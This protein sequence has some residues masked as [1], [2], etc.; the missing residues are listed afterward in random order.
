MKLVVITAITEYS[1]DIKKILKTSNVKAFSFKEVTGY[2]DISEENIDSN[3][4]GSDMNET[5][6]VL[7]YAFV[8]LKDIDSLFANIEA[9]NE[10]QET[11]S[12]IHLVSLAIEKNNY[13]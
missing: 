10:Q 1:K 8:N 7:F 4:F 3:W 9:F 11:I 12:K 2:K 13:K 6:S 5:D